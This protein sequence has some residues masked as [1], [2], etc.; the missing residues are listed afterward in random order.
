MKRILEHTNHRN[1]NLLALNGARF[2][3][4]EM[5][6]L[7]TVGRVDGV[8]SVDVLNAIRLLGGATALRT[9]QSDL[10]PGEELLYLEHAV[11]RLLGPGSIVKNVV[12]AIH[13]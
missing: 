2:C 7:A 11:R 9:H 10:T 12:V 8:E 6:L 13:R 4:W 3:D 5:C 1:N